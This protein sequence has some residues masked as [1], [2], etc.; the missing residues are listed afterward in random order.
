MDVL[1]VDPLVP[2]ALSWLQERHDVSYRPELGDDPIKL[3]SHTYKTRAIVLPPHVVVSRE[4]LDFSPKLL[5]IA[6]MQISSD[7]TDLE[8]CARR[9]VRVV[10]ARSATVRSN[11]EY[12]LYGLLMLYRRGMISA[13]LGRQLAQVRMGRELAGST[14]GLLGLA[15]VAHT[16]APML[17]A[18][19]VRLL[20]YDPAVHH[21]A[22]IWDKL[23]VEPVSLPELLARSDAVS[24]QVVYAVRFRGWLNEH[25]LNH[26]K[27]GQLWVGVSRSSLFDPA[28][29]A[30]ALTD[31]RID[32]CLLD[33]ANPN[34]AAEGSPL[35][36]IPNLHL[37]P[38]L[39]S[40]TREAKLRS[41]WYVAHRV[42]E[43]LTPS[44]TR[45]DPGIRASD[46]ALLDSLDIVGNDD[47][48]SISPSQ[49]GS[50]EPPRR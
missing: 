6:R 9:Q 21:A 19:G 22:P 43:T 24:L 12:L 15:P 37:T 40:H 47:P 50:L 49:W 45:G 20:G 25:V 32:A 39:G 38:R 14:V 35:F 30:H 2:E 16:L 23:G 31:G 36:G 8:A 17:K 33:G 41:S 44:T 18:M 27:P 42:H 4:F 3:R 11:A 7:N 13:L 34:F 29:L 10:Q 48:Q 1:L 26:C 46:F 28:A 5:L